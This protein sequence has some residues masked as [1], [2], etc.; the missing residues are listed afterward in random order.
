MNKIPHRPESASR[1]HPLMQNTY[2]VGKGWKALFKC[3][4]C[5]RKSWQHLNFLGRR[6]LVCHGNKWSKQYIVD[7]IKMR[8]EEVQP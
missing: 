1:V 6:K 3:K 4:I 2:Y 5:D 7:L 8:N